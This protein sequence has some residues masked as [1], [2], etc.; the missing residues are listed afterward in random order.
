M[1]SC[2]EIITEWELFVSKF[3]NGSLNEFGKWLMHKTQQPNTAILEGDLQEYFDKN[4]SE[5]GYSTA[6]SEA[7]YLIWRLSKFIKRYTKPLFSELGINNQ[8][9]F[10]ILAHIDYLKESPK[11]K[12][13]EDNLIDM[14]SGIDMIGRLVNRD[15]L[16]ERPN[17]TDKR[18]KL[19][20]LTPSG[21]KLLQDVYIGFQS[22]PDVLVDMSDEQKTFLVERLKRLDDYHTNKNFKL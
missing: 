19:I 20:S 14:S 21:A 22:I 3:P 1:R 10:A 15:L 13:V 2:V 7:T 8:D 4:T 5:F 16:Q 11:K 18:E 6:N 17:P 12:I 9:E